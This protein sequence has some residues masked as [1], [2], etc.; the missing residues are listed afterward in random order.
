MTHNLRA[1]LSTLAVFLAMALG[2]SAPGQP[3][4]MVAV[5]ASVTPDSLAPGGRGVVAI[6]FTIEPEWHIYPGDSS[7][8]GDQI[9][10]KVGL[11]PTPGLAFRAAVWPKPEF[12]E[13]GLEGKKIMV[14]LHSGTVVVYVPFVVE[15]NAAT[16]PLTINIKAS[17]QAC[18]DK[19][20]MPVEEVETAA[21]VKIAADGLLKP[22][23]WPAGFDPTAFDRMPEAKAPTAADSEAG[24]IDLQFFKLDPNG[25]SGFA[26]LLLVCM[27]AGFILNLMPCVL[28]VIPIKIA[29]FQ[30]AAAHQGG[31]QGR[32]VLLGMMT[33]LGI[34][35][36]WF[37]IAVMISVLKVINSVNELFGN[38][39]FQLIAATVIGL[40]A[41][42]MMGAF[43]IQLPQW[44]QGVSV[45]H[46][47]L[48]GSFMF[49][50]MTAVLGTPC[51]GPFVG[52]ALSW[53][54][55]QSNALVPLTA[56]TAVGVGMA[57]PYVVLAAFPGLAKKLPKAGPASDLLKTVLGLLMIAVAVFFFAN[58]L[59]ALV[60]EMPYIKDVLH[61]WI[62]TAL[63]LAAAGLL[64]FR[65][66]PLAKS[67]LG[68]LF[69]LLIALA[70]GGGM[71]WWTLR[72]Q[73][74]HHTLWQQT[75]GKSGGETH[76][77]WEPFDPER[78]MA[79]LA[80]GKVVVVDFT[81]TWCINCQFLKAG[82]LSDPEV[83]KQLQSQGVVAMMADNTSRK[84][85]GWQRLAELKEVGIPVVTVE[86]PGLIEPRRIYFGNTAFDILEAIRAAK[87]T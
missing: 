65:G 49:G 74:V 75:G 69:V 4:S 5:S 45:G 67:G 77:F 86:G 34:V 84:A 1:L 46:D 6:T 8:T 37:V 44:I 50:V 80:E 78:R 51:F 54:T 29:G 56:M 40:M 52:A 42:G 23:S 12:K 47:S 33:A 18:D 83:V 57:F 31:G 35:A 58:G 19:I 66:V 2:A 59:I 81:A 53:A 76:G 63:A 60:A 72:L 10:S 21:T 15:A 62:M 36:F 26:L 48:K 9:P 73:G 20:C 13:L 64:V 16:G 22:A 87:G 25:I 3:P 17:A 82:P 39:Y 79:L 61:W 30:R 70:I 11:A 43:T 24:L 28:P 38:P 85:P 55:Q 68:K 71:T 7:A 27:F 41:V 32:A 14:G